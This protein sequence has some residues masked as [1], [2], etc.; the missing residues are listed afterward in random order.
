MKHLFVIHSHTNFL[1][2]MGTINY[3]NLKEEEVSIAW[4]RNYKNILYNSDCVTEDLSWATEYPILRKLFNHRKDI[5][6]I[7]RQI[8]IL[9]KGDDY[10]LYAPHPSETLFALL[11][12]NSH[13]VGFNYL[14]EGALIM[15]GLF[16]KRK[17]S[18]E[19]CM[20]DYIVKYF[21]G[22]RL[23]GARNT[24]DIPSFKELRKTPECFAISDDI[25]DG[26]NYKTNII[27]WPSYN[28]PDKYSIDPSY[29]CFITE[30]F[31]EKDVVEKEVYLNLYKELIET[32]GKE[33]N[34]IKFHPAQWEET[35]KEIT[36][37]FENAGKKVKE[38]PAN[39]PFEV[40][41]SSYKNMTVC[42]FRSSLVVFAGQLGHDSYSLEKELRIQSAK[43]NKWREEMELTKI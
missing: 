35:K 24:W 30:S 31:I 23:Y 14:Q 20:Y 3:L 26:S 19:Y 10:I 37:L 38:L 42:G 4:S 36:Q 12:T 7:D 32:K 2:A 29:P 8:D 22:G 33:Y 5:I 21:Y 27:K 25:F 17:K 6:K 39:F 1:T 9:T 43:Y 40:Y 18:F 11:L 28:I 13:C 16:Q 15:K 41:L 34:Y